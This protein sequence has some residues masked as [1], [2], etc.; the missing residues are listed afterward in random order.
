MPGRLKSGCTVAFLLT[1]IAAMSLATYAA[2]EVYSASE[3]WDTQ[4]SASPATALSKSVILLIT[5][6]S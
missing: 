6:S 3:F 1:R 2:E 4:A 5:S